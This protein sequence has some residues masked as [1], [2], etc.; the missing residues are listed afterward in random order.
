MP[1]PTFFA[2]D[3]LSVAH[4]ERFQHPLQAIVGCRYNYK[5]DMVGHEA[6]SENFNSV[7]IAVLFKP[8][9]IRFAIF[10]CE[11]NIF[12]AIASLCHV[13]RKVGKYCSWQSGHI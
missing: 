7:L 3:P 2:V 5:M 6:V 1:L 12:T 8:Q 10:I 4:M 9:Q 13:M 11:K